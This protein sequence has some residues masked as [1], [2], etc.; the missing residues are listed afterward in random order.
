MER[1]SLGV[2]PEM[3]SVIVKKKRGEK[4]LQNKEDSD[5][6][7]KCFWVWPPHDKLQTPRSLHLRTL[8]VR[9]INATAIF[10][11]CFNRLL[12]FANRALLGSILEQCL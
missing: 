11:C 4:T 8:V 9:C 12:Q 6:L 1:R 5:H 10:L 2:R 3:K 7:R